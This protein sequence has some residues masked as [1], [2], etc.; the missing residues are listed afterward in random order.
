VKKNLKKNLKMLFVFALTALLVSGTYVL[1]R[2]WRYAKEPVP[3]AVN[4]T[5]YAREESGSTQTSTQ[6]N[7]QTEQ[8]TT[9][10]ILPAELNFKMDFYSQAPFGNWDFPWQEACEEASALLIANV[11]YNHQ[12]TATQFNDQILKMV[13]WEMENFGDYKDTTVAQIRQMLKEYFGLDSVVHENPTFEDMQRVLAKGHLIIMTFAGKKLGNPNYRNGGPVYHA[14]VIKGYKA[15]QKVI[16]ADV[17]TKNGEDYVYTWKVLQNA[18]HDYTN[19]IES[20][21]KRM[22]EVL[23]P[24]AADQA[25]LG[26]GATQ[27]TG[28]ASTQTKTP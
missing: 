20:G 7:T 2:S 17:G 27:T 15:G 22:I 28:T 1:Y 5:D 19:P 3:A 12:W 9:E 11:Y 25:A 21:A 16:T 18:L 10:Q 26:A 24:A 13:Q 6:I 14:I 4:L 23:P 8:V